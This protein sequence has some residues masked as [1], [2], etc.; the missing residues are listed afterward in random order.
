MSIRK[1][2]R[3]LLAVCLTLFVGHATYAAT[4]EL[5]L[6]GNAGHMEG[7]RP[8]IE[9]F[10]ASQDRIHVNVVD[11]EV[12]PEEII[13]RY[14][15]ND[16]PDII[17][18]A[19]RFTQDFAARGMM[20]DLQPFIDREGSGFMSDFYPATLADNTVDGHLYSLPAFLQIEGMYYNS[21]VL[22]RRGIA[23]PQEGWTWDDLRSMARSAR[24]VRSDGTFETWGLVAR[25]PI[26]LDYV[27]LGQAGAEI[28]NADGEITI[29][30]DAV[31]TTYNWLVSA[32]NEDILRYRGIH[33]DAPDDEGWGHHSAFVADATYRQNTWNT[34]EAAMVTAP[35]LRQSVGSDPATIFSDRSWGIMNVSPERQAAAWEV[36]KYLLEAENA[37]QFVVNLG[38]LPATRSS[39]EHDIWQ[40]YA[41]N[42]PNPSIWASLYLPIRNG[43]PYPTTYAA[44]V[45][46]QVVPESQALVGN[47][48]TIAEFIENA[49]TR[50]RTA[51]SEMQ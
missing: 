15:A 6:Q 27:M 29:D 31:R 32:V 39:F 18:S 45:V 13:T 22:Q 41:A 17:E 47:R 10:N 30:S 50:L 14:L 7:V 4:I 5:T 33:A 48:I 26:Q 28:I 21:E 23:P 40:D 43:T 34:L 12:N 24:Q 49:T 25:H 51:I 38:Y 19:G 20:A 44:A 46:A 3:V 2:T 8:I 42:H 1:V 11:K 9:A 37:A 16:M 35:P 36:I